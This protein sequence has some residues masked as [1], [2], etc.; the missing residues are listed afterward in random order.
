MIRWGDK[1]ITPKAAA[2]IILSESLDNSI[3]WDCDSSLGQTLSQEATARER[4]LIN[5]QLAKIR[6]R[7]YRDHLNIRNARCQSD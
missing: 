1:K 3:L 4:I 7:I 5:D 2:K 6:Q